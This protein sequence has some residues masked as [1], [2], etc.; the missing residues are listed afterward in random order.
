MVQK[1]QSMVTCPYVLDQ[2]IMVVG[3]CGRGGYFPH[4]RQE[5]ESEEGTGDQTFKGMSSGTYY[6]SEAYLLPFLELPKIVPLAEGQVFN[7]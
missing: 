3:M 1:L 2:N 5:V 7:K 4:G 6:P